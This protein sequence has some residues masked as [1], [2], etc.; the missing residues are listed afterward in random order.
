MSKCTIV[1][2]EGNDNAT[3]HTD[4]APTYKAVW[5]PVE[6]GEPTRLVFC[7]FVP[8]NG[9]LKGQLLQVPFA[10]IVAVSEKT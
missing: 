7:V 2:D 3:Y 6:Q 1:V 9:Y 4:E 10:R 8:K 5:V